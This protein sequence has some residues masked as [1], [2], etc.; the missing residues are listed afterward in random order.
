[1]NFSTLEN[2]DLLE[3]F[4]LVSIPSVNEFSLESTMIFYAV[5]IST[6]ERGEKAER[7]T[8]GRYD[9]SAAT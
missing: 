1:M 3:A 5:Q 2:S 7:M 9:M 8:G 4:L 6:G